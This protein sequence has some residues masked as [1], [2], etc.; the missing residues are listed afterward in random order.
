MLAPQR[1]ALAVQY[2]HA[3]REAKD[4]YLE[5][6]I[7]RREL[8]DNYCLYNPHYDTVEGFPAWA[9]T[10][11]NAHRNDPREFVYSYE[12]FDHG[13]THDALWN[14]AQLQM[15]RTGKM[16]SYMRMYWAKKILEWSKT[17]EDALATA[18]ALNDR[19]E[20]DGRDPNGYVGVAWSI[21]GVHDRP[22]FNRPIFGAVRYMNANGCAKKFDVNRYIAQVTGSALPL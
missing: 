3:P 21:G 10:T 2:A 22:W 13:E 8:S 5:E 19:Y 16:H 4:T 6:L 14:A 1:V 17:P 11:L 9:K 20:L 7:I 18:I 15:V 12:E